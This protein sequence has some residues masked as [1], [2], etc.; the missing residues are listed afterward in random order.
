MP[1]SRPDCRGSCV[2]PIVVLGIDWTGISSLF[3]FL[4]LFIIILQHR[5]R[6]SAPERCY[7]A[8]SLTF[9]F[10]V[11][12][13]YHCILHIHV[14]LILPIAS[15]DY[16][17]YTNVK[18][19]HHKVILACMLLNIFNIARAGKPPL[20]RFCFDACLRI[21]HQLRKTGQ[22]VGLADF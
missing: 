9:F 16:I 14:S 4:L 21:E 1:D 15:S 11:C 19:L 18:M 7:L 8:S 17:S 3:S 13:S 20:V 22:I 5:L 10:F 2:C 6:L 12:I